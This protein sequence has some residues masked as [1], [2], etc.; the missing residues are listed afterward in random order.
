MGENAE[1][2]VQDNEIQDGVPLRSVDIEIDWRLT[3]GI[4]RQGCRLC[5]SDLPKA[6]LA[7]WG[8]L[9]PSAPRN[10]ETYLSQLR[11][12]AIRGIWI[13]H[14]R[15]TCSMTMLMRDLPSLLIM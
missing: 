12:S 2:K 6:C 4:G 3:A 14:C 10:H 15:E 5:T 7:A 13:S 8:S 11:G 9:Q 1:D